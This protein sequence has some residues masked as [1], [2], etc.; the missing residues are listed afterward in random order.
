MDSAHLL[1]RRVLANAVLLLFV[2]GAALLFWF[3]PEAHRFYPICPIYT[4][5]GV[6]CPGCGATRALAALLHGE[7][8]QALALNAL[9]VAALP[10]ALAAGIRAYAL[11]MRGE[12]VCWP[13]VPNAALYSS[14]AAMAIFTVA[15]ILR[16]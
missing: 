1:L 6:L 9:V 4:Y 16:W 10:L 11:A 15:R 14:L 8:R 12:R 7:L 13:A 5:L 2:C 3:P